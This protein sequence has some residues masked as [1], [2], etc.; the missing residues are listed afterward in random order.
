MSTGLIITSSTYAGE[1]AGQ[2]IAPALLSAKSLD[3]VT[4]LE[5]IKYKRVLNKV[6]GA[7]LVQEAGCD[8][9]EAGS[10]TLTEAVL[11]PKALKINIDLCSD[12]MAQDWMAQQMRA[13][14]NNNYI[15]QS[16]EE[17]V[18]GYL[19]ETV[20]NHVETNFW[21]GADSGAGFKELQQIQQESLQQ[22]LML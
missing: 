9:Y 10:L 14:R 6:E 19:G 15:P 2:Y 21:N 11:E 8:F 3:D 22:I 1:S 5:N 18:V 13:G 12:T 17:F 7:S 4:V 16:F 20:A